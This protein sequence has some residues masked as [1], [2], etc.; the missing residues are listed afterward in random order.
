MTEKCCIIGCGKEVFPPAGLA[1][2]CQFCKKKHCISHI[3]PEA[4]G[5]G[6][7]IRNEMRMQKDKEAAEARHHRTHVAG[8]GEL[9]DKMA[10]L[11]ADLEAKRAPAT[12]RK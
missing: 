10:K 6:D 2:P 3:I 4:H 5:C 8:K 12:K 7:A 9:K 1:K 11:R